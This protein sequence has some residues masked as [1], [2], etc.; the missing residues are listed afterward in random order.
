MNLNALLITALFAAG[1]YGGGYLH[2]R[3]DGGNAVQAD[4]DHAEAERLREEKQAVLDRIHDNLQAK[5]KQDADRQRLKKG[6]ADEIAQI[7]ATYNASRGL[8]INANICAGFTE[9]TEADGA[10]GSDDRTTNTRL[11]PEPYA[12]NLEELMLKADKIVASCRVGQQ[13]LVENGMAP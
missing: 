5:A 7:H 4:W 10:S 1:A 9:G 11:L 2:G 13:F 3:V 12:G 8:R 6:H